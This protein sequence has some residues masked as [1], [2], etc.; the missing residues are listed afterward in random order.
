MGGGLSGCVIHCGEARA[1]CQ[2][3][4]NRSGGKLEAKGGLAG[5]KSLDGLGIDRFGKGCR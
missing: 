5:F 1:L 2:E 4:I 3:R